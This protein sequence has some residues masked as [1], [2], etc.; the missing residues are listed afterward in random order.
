MTEYHIVD[1]I[2]SHYPNSPYFI[3]NIDNF[4]FR[5]HF[6][7]VFEL[8]GWVVL[9]YSHVL[10]LLMFS[11]SGYDLYEEISFRS[12]EASLKHFVTEILKG[13]VLLHSIGIIHND[14]KP[15]RKWSAYTVIMIIIS[16]DNLLLEPKRPDREA[17][18]RMIKIMD[19]GLSCV[20]DT[21]T[22]SCPDYYIQT[23][24]YRSPEVM[25]AIPYTTA[26][27]MWSL[28]VIVGEFF[29]GTEFIF[30]ETEPDQMAAIM[31][32]IGLPPVSFI[33]QSDRRHIYYGNLKHL[34]RSMW[35]TTLWHS[36]AVCYVT[37]RG[38]HRRP[39][40]KSITKT[41]Q[42]N[43]PEHDCFLDFLRRLLRWEPSERMSADEALNHPW[44]TGVAADMDLLPE[45]RG[46]NG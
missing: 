29:R 1:K 25:L 40:R 15:V 27:D 8:L 42:L 37:K 36:E 43:E 21:K 24:Y 18:L 12:E 19:F 10:L 7:M 11:E 46:Y 17:D 26:S 33:E 45:L 35:E 3:R 41:L 34:S 39:Y 44:I 38:F 4:K 14:M 13:L 32:N 23:R 28:G 30:G 9:S 20:R 5:N 6:C 2:N 22:M 31:E 16:Q